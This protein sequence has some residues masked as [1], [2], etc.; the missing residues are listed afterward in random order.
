[1][2]QKETRSRFEGKFWVAVDYQLG[3]EGGTFLL[4]FTQKRRGWLVRCWS[5]RASGIRECL[6]ALVK[7]GKKGKKK[8]SLFC[9]VGS[10]IS[11]AVRRREGRGR[12]CCLRV[13]GKRGKRVPSVLRDIA[14]ILKHQGGKRGEVPAQFFEQ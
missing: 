2:G 5:E 13:Q 10:G 7:G 4:G 14:C 11:C 8:V 6:I 9:W 1:M 3:R 12:A